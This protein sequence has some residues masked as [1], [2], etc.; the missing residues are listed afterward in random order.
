MNILLTGATGFVGLHFLSFFSKNHT[1]HHIFAAVRTVP[2]EE[3]PQVTWLGLHEQ[4]ENYLR[5]HNIDVVLHLLGKAHDTKNTTE[6]EEYDKVNFIYTR[7]LYNA[8]VKS[9]AQKFIFLSTIKAVGDDKTYVANANDLSIPQTPYAKSKKKAEDYIRSCVLPP[10]KTFYILRPTLIYGPR[11]KG[12]LA[13]LV[14]FAKKGLP[15]PFSAFENKRS[16]LSVNNLCYIIAVLLKEDLKSFTLNIANEDSLSTKE[17]IELVAKKLGKTPSLLNIPASLIKYAARLGDLLRI[18]PFD[19]EKLKKITS[20]FVVDTS[21]M[22]K[23][24]GTPLPEKTRDS[25]TQIIESN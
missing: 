2:Q 15:Y 12:N 6:P 5:D 23:T 8:F 17:I 21:E 1:D 3:F 25:I 22:E 20:S 7:D 4:W 10:D 16:Y 11:V 13:T 9:K 14:K 18:L 19:S 24:L